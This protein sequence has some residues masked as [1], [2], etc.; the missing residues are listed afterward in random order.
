MS[1]RL[2]FRPDARAAA[3]EREAWGIIAAEARKIQAKLSVEIED[4]GFN[5]VV[6]R[7]ID[8]GSPME[9]VAMLDGGILGPAGDGYQ[10]TAAEVQDIDGPGELLAAFTLRAKQLLR[11]AIGETVGHLHHANGHTRPTQ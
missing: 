1:D 11:A 7:I 3:L 2:F 8:S 9:H 6:R 4:E 5:A 10:I